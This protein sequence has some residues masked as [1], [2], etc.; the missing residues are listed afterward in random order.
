MRGISLGREEVID[1][2][3]AFLAVVIIGVDDC[4]RSVDDIPCRKNCLACSPWLCA[5]LREGEALRKIGALLK[6]IV[7]PV[8]FAGAAFDVL[9]EDVF[10]V[11]LDY[12][13]DPSESCR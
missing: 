2:Y 4:E 6:C 3:E 7:N 8:L 1:L 12:K 11:V 9:F 10:E 13:A 5:A